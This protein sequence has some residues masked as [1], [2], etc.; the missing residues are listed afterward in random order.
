MALKVLLAGGEALLRESLAGALR[1]SG[2]QVKACS[3]S[4]D[5]V[6]AAASQLVPDAIVCSV[7]TIDGGVLDLVRVLHEKLARGNVLLVVGRSD[8][9]GAYHALLAGAAGYVPCTMGLDQLLHAVAVVA[10]GHCL[11]PAGVLTDLLRGERGRRPLVEGD[12]TR[13]QVRI[14]GAICQGLS[15]RQIARALGLSEPLVK[16]EVKAILRK[17]GTR[18]RAEAVATA[19][20]RGVIN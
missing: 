8:P 20:Q 2:L 5:D 15:D 14:L 16:S 12:L 3:A 19:L 18:N 1:A 7:A 13:R 6:V 9:A 17:T 4:V 11:F 10:A